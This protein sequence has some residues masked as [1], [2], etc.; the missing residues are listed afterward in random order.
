MSRYIR[1]CY[2]GEILGVLNND[3]ERP[4]SAYCL[5]CLKEIREGSRAIPEQLQEWER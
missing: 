3:E 2:C 5:K 1:C 4:T